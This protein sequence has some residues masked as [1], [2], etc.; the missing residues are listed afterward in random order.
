MGE[1][2]KCPYC[3]EYVEIDDTFDTEDNAF[4]NTF[5]YHVVGSCPKC[6]KTFQWE[7]HYRMIFNGFK[8]VTEIK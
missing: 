7:E 1:S 8:N 5:I 4:D 6:N 3:G 2:L